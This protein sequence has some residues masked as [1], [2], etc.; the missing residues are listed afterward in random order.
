MSLPLTE[1]PYPLALERLALALAIGLFVGLERERRRKASGVRTFAFVTL[2]GCLGGLLGDAYALLSIFLLGVLIVFL[3]LQTLRADR[4]TELT[5]SAALLVMG[6]VG[7][8]CGQGHTFTPVAVA[9]ATAALLAWKEPLRGFSVHLSDAELQSA[10]L[11]AILAFVIYPALPTGPID[12]WH[13]LIPREAF[14]TVILIAGIG[15]VNYILWKIYGTRGIELTGFLGGLVNS[16]VAVSELAA[17]V[18]DTDGQLADVAYRGSILATAA[19]VVRNTAILAI[20]DP[21]ALTSGAL[22]HV[23][24]LLACG[25]L[26]MLHRKPAAPTSEAPLLHLESPF[27]LKAAL[28][29]GCI[30]LI[31]QVVVVLAQQ[32]L[33]QV[34]VYVTSMLGGFVSSASAVA[35]AASLSSQGSIS[36]TTAGISAIIASLTSAAINLP[37]IMRA[38]QRDL[39][40]RFARALGAMLVFGITGTL[41]QLFTMQNLRI[42]L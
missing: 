4:G 2:L 12:P 22:G 18:Q 36:S 9:V 10:I 8:L 38:Q 21:R 29:Y 23:G 17:R 42:G 5:T 27:S 28:K 3:N 40:W 37:L 33:G 1:W 16:T 26:I 24:M 30:F 31:L 39:T 6:V 25:G 20:L 32:A 13:V 14:L 19:M 11:L 41:I 7:V 34:G 35:A 15:F